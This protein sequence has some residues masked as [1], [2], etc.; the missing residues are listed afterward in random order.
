[1]NG[2]SRPEKVMHQWRGQGGGS[3]LVQACPDFALREPFP[4]K[5]VFEGKYFAHGGMRRAETELVTDLYQ[6]FFYLG[7]PFV[8]ETKRSAAW[9]YD[10]SCLL[11]FDA[12]A[13]RAFHAAWN[14]IEKNVR[15]G[16]WS[17]ANIY[18]MILH[19]NDGPITTEL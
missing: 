8:P 19:G 2:T 1:M 10:Y 11:A 15:G 12:S 7:L 4:F 14:S 9:E 16:F 17:G 3:P 5:I 6:A 13:D 18:V